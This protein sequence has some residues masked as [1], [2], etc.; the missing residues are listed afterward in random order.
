MAKYLRYYTEFIARGGHVI[1]AEIHQESATAPVP[2]ELDIGSGDSPLVIEWAE[3]GKIEPVQGSAARLMLNSASDRQLL[4]F[5]QIVKAADVRLDVKRDNVLWWSGTLDSEGY[6]EPY[7]SGNNYDVTLTFSDFG[8]LNRIPWSRTGRES[9][10]TIL[11][12]CLSAAG[13]NYGQLVEHIS[14]LHGDAVNN[15]NAIDFTQVVLNND[16][17]YDEEGKEMSCMEV[18]KGILQ[19]FALRIIQRAGKIYIYDLNAAHALT[20]ADVEWKG[21]DAAI[22]HD[23]VFNDA[24]VTFSPYGVAPRAGAWIETSSQSKSD[25]SLWETSVSSSQL[26]WSGSLQASIRWP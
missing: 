2:E 16:N 18:L 12:A 14:T 23:E 4:P 10:A 7:N 17:F 13:I 8:A 24:T 21:D 19:P 1:R 5:A 25:P 15:G 22:S 11:A 6:E 26:A 20:A 9:Y 3:T